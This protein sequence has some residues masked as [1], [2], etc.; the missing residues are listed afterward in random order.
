MPYGKVDAPKQVR[1][2]SVTSEKETAQLYEESA[3]CTFWDKNF[4]SKKKVKK[5]N[6][7]PPLVNLTCRDSTNNRLTIILSIES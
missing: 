2:A 7:K 4:L 1:T 3:F 6:G 5:D